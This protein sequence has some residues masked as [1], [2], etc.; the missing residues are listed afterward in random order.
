MI[1]NACFNKLLLFYAS[2]S[3]S[4]KTCIALMKNYWLLLLML[5]FSNLFSQEES[6]IDTIIANTKETY[7]FV[8]KDTTTYNKSIDFSEKKAFKEDLSKKYDGKDFIYTEEKPEVKKKPSPTS[9]AFI[10]GIVFFFSKIFPFL[11]GGI[12]VIIIL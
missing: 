8:E 9:K 5:A 1:A 2:F 12:L 3:S 4:K 7:T 10:N 11:L 6:K